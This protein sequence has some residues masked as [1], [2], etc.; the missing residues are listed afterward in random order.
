MSPPRPLLVLLAIAEKAAAASLAMQLRNLACVCEPVEMLSL[1]EDLPRLRAADL[2][3]LQIGAGAASCEQAKYFADILPVAAIAEPEPELFFQA[4]KAGVETV[5]SLPLHP[6][7]IVHKLEKLCERL[8]AQGGDFKPGPS[9]AVVAI[10]PHAPAHKALHATIPR[11]FATSE[12]MSEVREMIEKVAP[13]SA[14]VLLCGE[15]GVGKELAARLIHSRSPRAGQAFIKVNCAAIPNELLESE[16]FG[17]EA[18]AFTGAVKAKPGKFELANG[19]TIFLD[20]IGEMHP[21]LQAKLLHVLQDGDFARLGGKRDLSVDVRVICATNQ[22]LDAL[23]SEG[24]FREDL[25]YRV[26]VITIHLPPLRARKREIPELLDYFVQ[27]YSKVYGKTVAPID[28][29][30]MTYLMQ[31]DWPGNIRE[32]ENLCKRYVIVGGTT[33]ILRDIA[34]R[35]RTLVAEEPL[36]P[37]PKATPVAATVVEAEVA[38]GADAVEGVPSLIQIGKRA[39]WVAERAAIEEMLRE[40]RWNRREA[41]KRLNVSYKALLNKIQTLNEGFEVSK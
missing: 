16:L 33:Q 30:T 25:Y 2:L 18:G 22:Q 8:R 31:H 35:H 5:L 20:E 14:T 41:A 13:T 21:M 6:S 23:V 3:L 19:G 7:D 39:A 15:S 27:R 24:R 11:L 12:E 10:P 34:A 29:T 26:N 36:L 9:E 17:F 38:P 40:T 4:A 1:A 37:S 28:E 32:L